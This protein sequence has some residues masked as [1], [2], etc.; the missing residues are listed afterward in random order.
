M[1][2]YQINIFTFTFVIS[3]V[4]EDGVTFSNVWQPMMKVKLYLKNLQ[5]ARPCTDELVGTVK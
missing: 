3:E 2:L 4:Q 5:N 1:G